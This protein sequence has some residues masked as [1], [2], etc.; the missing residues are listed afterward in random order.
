VLHLSIF[1]ISLRSSIISLF[2]WLRRRRVSEV[3]RHDRSPWKTVA[4]DLRIS[5]KMDSS[6]HWN[7]KIES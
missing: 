6:F 3:R 2:R 7:D 4:D 5:E 1:L